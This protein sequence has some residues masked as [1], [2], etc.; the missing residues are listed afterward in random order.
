[1]G[2]GQVDE[3]VAEYLLGQIGG[4]DP[5]QAKRALQDVCS[6]HARGLHFKPHQRVTL[7][8]TT[9]GQ[10]EVQRFDRKVRRWCLNVL[11]LIG[12][13]ERSRD[14]IHRVI[15]IFHNDPDTMAS[16][17]TAYFKVSHDAYQD[18]SSRSFISPQQIAIAAHI[19]DFGTRIRAD[20]TTIDIER[21]DRTI[22]CRALVAVGLNRAPENLFHPRYANAELVKKLSKHDEESVVQ[23]AVWAINENAN[24]NVDHLAFELCDLPSL[25]PSI[26][27]WTYRLYGEA[28]LDDGLKHEI[29]ADGSKDI[30]PEARMGL[31]RGLRGT[32]YDGLEEVTSPWWHDENEAPIREELLDHMVRHASQCSEYE[33]L[34]VEQFDAALP[35][36]PVLKRLRA[37]A[38]GTPLYA[39]FRQ[40]EYHDGGDLF[41]FDEPKRGNITIMTTNNNVTIGNVQ[42]GA[43]AVGGDATQTGTN[44]NALSGDQTVQLKADLNQLA[45]ELR[46]LPD[47]TPEVREV[48]AL[49]E[50]AESDPN[51]S[52]LKKLKGA[53]SGL[54]SGTTALAKFGGD[55]TKVAGLAE[56]II[57]MLPF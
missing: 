6:L 12:T 55:A 44:Q 8:V 43:V 35:N 39:R 19:G 51:P 56:K 33:R 1:M 3:L 37:A 50:D 28:D 5:Q 54:F 25:A 38:A 45:K 26:R 14:A 22:L 34:A 30:D 15:E 36:D 21:E 46:A 10:L 57:T 41:G 29:I 24:L 32:W 52:K 42:G 48:T 4:G 9:V 17:L 27:G 18:L 40:M 2:H 11:A 7:E 16:A 20:Q 47:Q 49:V 53:L 23:Y 13:P 31:A